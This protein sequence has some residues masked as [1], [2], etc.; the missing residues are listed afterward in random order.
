MALSASIRTEKEAKVKNLL[1]FSDSI[2]ARTKDGTLTTELEKHIYHSFFTLGSGLG[3]AKAADLDVRGTKI[4]NIAVNLRR[5]DGSRDLS[6]LLC[7]LRVFAVLLLDA[8]QSNTA[9]LNN[10]TRLLRASLK[11]ARSCVDANELDLCLKVLEKGANYEA[12]FGKQASRGTTED[13]SLYERLSSEYYTMRTALAWRQSRLDIAEHMFERTVRFQQRADPI[14]SERAADVFYEIGKNLAERRQDELAQKWLERAYDALEEQEPE[15][16]SSDAEELR[17]CIMHSIVRNLITQGTEE[18]RH[19]AQDMTKLMETYFGDKMVVS[20]LKLELLAVEAELDVQAYKSALLNMIRTVVL[21]EPSFK[22]LLHH[23]HKLKKD[24]AAVAGEC[25]DDFLHLRLYEAGRQEWLEKA[26]IVRIWITIALPD[27]EAAINSVN[28]LLESISRNFTHPLTAAAAH[29]ILTILWKC[30]D[31]AYNQSQFDIAQNWCRIARHQVL[32]NAGDF[33]IA[34]IARKAMQ[35]SLAQN[36]DAAVRE[37]FFQMPLATRDAPFTR[38]LMYKLAI[39]SNDVQ[40][41]AESLEAVSRSSKTDP[42]LL[43]ACV[44]EAQQ[45]GNRQQAIVALQQ[46]LN[47]T[48]QGIPTDV[49]L[50]AILRCTARLIITELTITSPMNDGL[51]DDFC[52]L[53]E[54]AAMRAKLQRNKALPGPNE[55]FSD[56][57]VEWFSKNAYNMALKHCTDIHPSFIVRLLE[58]CIELTELVHARR[59]GQSEEEYLSKLLLCN[60]LATCALVTLARAEDNIQAS[61]QHYLAVNRHASQF[62]DV[63]ARMEQDCASSTDVRSKRFQIL[64]FQLE[65]AL[66]FGAWDQLDNLLDECLVQDQAQNLEKLADLILSIHAALVKAN[67]GQRHQSK[68][69]SVVQKI[70]KASCH[71]LNNDIVKVSRWFRCLFSMALESDP[72][73]SLTCLDE[74]A[75]I[76]KQGADGDTT[77]TSYPNEEIEWLTTSSFNHAIDL[78]CASDDGGCRLWAE[79]ALMLAKANEATTGLHRILESKYS[80]LRWE[81]Q[82]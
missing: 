43:Y 73:I 27:T 51:L 42:K 77:G 35:C 25:L 24:N 69:L 8:A 59:D 74:V 57:E 39:R 33:N 14:T 75:D 44:L 20:L 41:A 81:S 11:A 58:A 5:D 29:A 38:F 54:V 36:D 1:K 21:T 65:A 12:D 9:N 37:V 82:E 19:K 13:Q 80:G 40:L 49:H 72:D 60:F 26:I 31:G 47:R 52:K 3:G 46:V 78:Y 30:I 64:L 67:V 34:I 68:V 16:L 28:C 55:E 63:F 76:V 32:R 23:I 62:V 10:C 70:V 7:L 56:D 15:R 2:A 4:W 79:K 48:S 53:F 6:R 17:L 61:R 66:K 50:P 18:A 71:G 45:C 22:T